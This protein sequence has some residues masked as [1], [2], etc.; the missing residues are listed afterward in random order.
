VPEL[1][2]DL[3]SAL[4]AGCTNLV[5]D[6]TDVSYA[7]SSALGLL[8][9]LDH[10]VR[11]LEGKIVLA[12]ANRDVI[13]IIE[14]SGLV[15]VAG[16]IGMSANVDGAI[17]GLSLSEAPS[18]TLWE[19]RIEIPCDVNLLAGV[20]EEVSQII[21]PLGFPESAL[22]DIKVAVGEALANAVRHGQ[23]AAGLGKVDVWISAYDDRVVIEIADEGV[24]F[25]GVHSGS[26]DLYA[27]SGRGIMFMR[28]LMDRV[29]F[30]ASAGGGTL[31]RL[32]KHRR[33]E[34]A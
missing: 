24:G 31:V 30:S 10:R 12:G 17:E 4:E 2:R 8:V 11:P 19:H 28:A 23:P 22:F 16:S 21:A 3:D 1:R 29:E 18:G 15:N 7:D 25:D 20:R 9:W 26:S 13:R 34:A 33:S 5:L 14:L 32:V 6:F 27:P